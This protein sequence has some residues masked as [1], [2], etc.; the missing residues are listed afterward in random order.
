MKPDEQAPRARILRRPVAVRTEGPL[1]WTVRVENPG[2]TTIHV[3]TAI[4]QIDPSDDGKTLRISTERATYDPSVNF[5]FFRLDT[6][7]LQP[8]E[9]LDQPFSL[10]F[11]LRLVSLEGF[12]PQAFTRLWRPAPNFTLA[13]TVAF[14]DRPFQAPSDR[15]RLPASLRSWT[16]VLRPP[17]MRLTVS[18]DTEE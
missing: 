15:S 14:G 18:T 8:G 11:P 9:T 17:A 13:T 5:A 4:Q 16:K 10:E 1:Q 12:P 6:T 2:T 3:A 7:P